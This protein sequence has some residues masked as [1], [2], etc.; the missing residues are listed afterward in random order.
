MNDRMNERDMDRIIRLNEETNEKKKINNIS[1]SQKVKIAK[2][3]T[4][5]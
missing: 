1:N 2:I 4:K 3:W 5:E